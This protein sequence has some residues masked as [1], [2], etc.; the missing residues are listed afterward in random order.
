MD[1][2][3]LVIDIKIIDVYKYIAINVEE[4]HDTSNHERRIDHPLEVGKKT[5]KVI[6]ITKDEKGGKII[7]TFATV[8]TKTYVV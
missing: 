6:R 8:T 2:D 5:R 7:K 1:T 3:S 4:R